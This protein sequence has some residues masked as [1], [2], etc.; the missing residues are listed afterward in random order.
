MKWL[1]LAEGG[2]VEVG[3]HTVTH[4]VLSALPVAAQRDE[5]EEQAKRTTSSAER[6]GE[7]SGPLAL[8]QP[9]SVIHPALSL[10]PFGQRQQP[11]IK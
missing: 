3:A 2:L 1:R 5:V 4:P 7:S 11:L 10:A 6:H 9:T 8:C